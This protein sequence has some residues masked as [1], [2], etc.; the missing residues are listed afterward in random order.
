MIFFQEGT[1]EK[2]KPSQEKKTYLPLARE[3]TETSG[4]TKQETV[5]LRQ[6]VGGDDRVLLLGRCMEQFEDI[7]REC[8]RDSGTV[9]IC[10]LGW[11]I[12]ALDAFWNRLGASVCV[13]IN[14]S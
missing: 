11:N 10:G 2:G 5:K 14:G 12:C 6:V 8:F 1:N 4:D 13:L 7:V 3:V 9:D